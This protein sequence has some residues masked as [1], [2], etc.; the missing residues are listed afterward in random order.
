MLHILGLC[1]CLEKKKKAAEELVLP[2]LTSWRS[3]EPTSECSPQI[4]C[5][6]GF[7]RRQASTEHSNLKDAWAAQDQV[8]SCL[9]ALPSQVQGFSLLCSTNHNIRVEGSTQ[10]WDR[11][12]ITGPWL[13]TSSK[14]TQQHLC[15]SRWQGWSRG[16][17]LSLVTSNGD[18]AVCKLPWQFITDWAVREPA[19]PPSLPLSWSEREQRT[20]G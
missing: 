7:P 13:L 1:P 8:P 10:V 19:A 18:K 15:F 3:W 6:P 16:F 14:G 12:A 4:P 11:A 5:L 9:C 20:V 17:L 2:A